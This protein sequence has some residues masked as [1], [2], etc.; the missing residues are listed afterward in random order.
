MGFTRVI[1]LSKLSLRSLKTVEPQNKNARY[2]PYG[3]NWPSDGITY[4]RKTMISLY[5]QY[6][7]E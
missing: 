3:R 2:S 7:D 5:P 4:F 6:I 1:P